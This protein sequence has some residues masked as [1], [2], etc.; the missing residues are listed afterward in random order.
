MFKIIFLIFYLLFTMGGIIFIKIGGND[1]NFSLIP[2]I[3]FNISYVMLLGFFLYFLSFFMW[4]KL[5]ILFD[6][7]F[8]GPLTAGLVQIMILLVGIFLFKEKLNIINICGIF[9]IVFGIVLVTFK[10]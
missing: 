7:T 2:S 10:R 5:L 9:I 6:I 1:L 4:Q 3:N 8:I